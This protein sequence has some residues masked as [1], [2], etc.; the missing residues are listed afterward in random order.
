MPNLQTLQ[1]GDAGF[2]GIDTRTNPVSLKEGVLQD[3]QNI[4]IEQ[5]ILQ[6][7]K[8]IARVLN[9]QQSLDVGTIY[10]AGVY[11]ISSGT[12]KIVLVVSNGL[13]LFDIGTQSLSTKYSFPAGRTITSGPVQVLQA[14]NKI[15]I[16]RGEA[17][18][19]ITGSGATGQ[20]ATVGGTGNTVITVTT[21]LPHGLVAGDEFAI[22]TNQVPWNGPTKTSNFVVGTV[23]TSTSFTY[24]LTTGHNGG[25]SGYVIQVGKPVLEF[26][27]TTVRITNQG[28]IDGTLT[29][30]T[31]TTACS[32]PFTSTAIY[33]GNRIFCK[34]SKDEIAVSDFLPTAAGD[35]EFDLTIQA[36]TINLG[37]EQSIT[38]FYPWV[39]DNVLVFKDNSVYVAKFADDTSTPNIVLASSYVENLTMELG[40]VAKNSIANVSGTIF[41]LSKKGVYALEPQLDANLLANTMPMS[42]D[43]QKYID[44]INQQ[45]V[46]LAVGK[47]YNGRYYLAVP[48]DSN[49]SNS[50]VLVY[51]LT[52]KMWESVDDHPTG[53]NPFSFIVAKNGSTSV[54]NRLFYCT[55]TNGI[56]LTEEKEVDE[57][58]D[59]VT[60][61]TLPF[62]LPQTLQT[63]T[64]QVNNIRGYAKTRK[65][66][67]QTMQSKRFVDINTELDFG[68]YGA[69]QTKITTYNPDTTKV[70][71]IAT[72]SVQNDKIRR[73]PIRKI[74]Y[75]LDIELTSVQGRPT[76]RTIGVSAV[77]I[78]KTTKN[79]D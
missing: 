20:N 5:Q 32:F 45:Y 24:T 41:F 53:V 55:P 59:I 61:L 43:I 58:G 1:E 48:L 56:Y 10:G 22:E 68:S 7:R 54:V 75:A 33:H 37:D 44:R 73:T 23:P 8:G 13:Y 34:Y 70:I 66:V 26:D 15:Y 12:E 31:T 28:V 51:N 71:D 30:G 60:A 16:L 77:H 67:F 3:G 11:R 39:K 78:G 79:E 4:R 27:G 42:I 2:L 74:A 65:Y 38:G 50:H 35:W 36:M 14:V 21:V 63:T 49:I 69:L 46:H 64:Y 57:Y 17:T 18:K 29:G 19:Y 25:A 76:I 9:G 6:V 40:C 62:Y 52:N 72:S 47:V